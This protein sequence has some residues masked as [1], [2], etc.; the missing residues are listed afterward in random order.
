MILFGPDAASVAARRAAGDIDGRRA[1]QSDATLLAA[2]EMIASGAFSRDERDRF[3]SLMASLWTDDLFF[4]AGHFRDYCAAQDMARARYQ[5]PAAWHRAAI[6]SIARVG[7]F[8]ADR[9][10]GQYMRDIWH[11][12]TPRFAAV[13]E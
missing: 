8:S 10:V 7:W 6:L 4:V 13:A 12:A 3:R 2:M 11:T 5:Q 9:T 1:I